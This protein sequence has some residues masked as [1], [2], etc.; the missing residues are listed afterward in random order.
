M[1]SL[2]QRATYLQKFRDTIRDESSSIL[3]STYATLVVSIRSLLMGRA[4]GCSTTAG[5]ISL[6][7]N[8]SVSIISVFVNNLLT[9]SAP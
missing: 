5:A 6:S 2:F 4:S 8:H 3:H 9:F 1:A 7:D